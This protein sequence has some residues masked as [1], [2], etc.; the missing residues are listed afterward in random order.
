MDN[1]RYIWCR[2]CGAIHHATPFDRAPI[3]AFT[4]GE[5]QE[6]PANE[7]RDFMR[8]HAG[9]RLEPMRETG[10]DHYANG[11][12]F[13]PMSVRY[14]EV[15]NGKDILLLRRS[16][17]SIEEPLGY[18]IVNGQLIQTGVTLEVQDRARFDK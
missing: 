1:D 4:G 9:H 3:Y 14:I 12:A 16:R 10:N 15:S 6:I 2:T 13:D 11:L 8:R 7:G 17:S 18:E 5:V